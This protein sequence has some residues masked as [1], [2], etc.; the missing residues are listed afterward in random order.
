VSY[1]LLLG[2]RVLGVLLLGVRVLGLQNPGAQL[3]LDGD[4][5]SPSISP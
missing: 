2:V 3:L 5:S 4:R 1:L